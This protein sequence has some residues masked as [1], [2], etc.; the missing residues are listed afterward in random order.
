MFGTCDFRFEMSDLIYVWVAMGVDLDWVRLGINPPW[1]MW[2]DFASTLS[3]TFIVCFICGI[4]IYT[5]FDVRVGNVICEALQIRQFVIW[6]KWTSAFYMDSG[7]TIKTSDLKLKWV[8]NLVNHMKPCDFNG[9]W[10]KMD[11]SGFHIDID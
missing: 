11:V 7:W 3:K 1:W 5:D 8:I 2:Q 10:M 9:I 4:W 6:R